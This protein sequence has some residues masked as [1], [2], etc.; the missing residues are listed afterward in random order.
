MSEVICISG[1]SQSGKD[2]LGI[3]MKSTLESHGKKVLTMHYADMVKA[4][5]KLYYHWD[6]NKNEEG[7]QLL[8]TL[9]TDIVRASDPDYWTDMVGRF[10]KATRGYYDVVL[11]PD[12]RFP[13][14]IE[15]LDDLGLNVTA[16]RINRY[17]NGKPFVNPAMTEEQLMH[18]SETSLDN[19]CGFDYVVENSSLHELQ[20]ASHGLLIDLGL[21][22]EE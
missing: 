7:R 18:P 22:E 4:Y 11:I 6:G 5:A 3:Y 8:Q 13:N 14:E 20:E 17:D 19:Y 10:I 15:H 21:I 9:G 12:A 1:K 2:T 16:I